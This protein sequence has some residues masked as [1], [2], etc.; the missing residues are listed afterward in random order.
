M[1]LCRENAFR[2]GE[3]ACL[4]P[5]HCRPIQSCPGLILVSA[6]GDPMIPFWERTGQARAKKVSNRRTAKFPRNYS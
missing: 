1:A 6:A 2:M 3:E 4:P 5:N